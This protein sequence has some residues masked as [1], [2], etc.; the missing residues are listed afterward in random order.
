[1]GNEKFMKSPEV[2]PA[3]VGSRI[4]SEMGLDPERVGSIQLFAGGVCSGTLVEF[5]GMEKHAPIRDGIINT[6][7]EARV[8]GRDPQEAI[9]SALGLFVRR[10]EQNDVIRAMPENVKKN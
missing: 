4:L 9:E 1:M 3:Q 2:D 8:A 10:D 7:A 6:V 5:M